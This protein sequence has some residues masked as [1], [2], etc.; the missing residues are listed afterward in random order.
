MSKIR[1]PNFLVP[2]P[3]PY[4]ASVLNKIGLPC[5][6]TDPYTSASYPSHGLAAWAIGN[7]FNSRF[8]IQKNYGKGMDRVP[9]CFYMGLLIH[10]SRYSGRYSQARAPQARARS[11]CCPQGQLVPLHPYFHWHHFNI[12]L[13]NKVIYL[14]ALHQRLELRSMLRRLWIDQETKYPLRLGNH[15]CVYV[16]AYLSRFSPIFS[17]TPFHSCRLRR[18]TTG[19]PLTENKVDNIVHADAVLDLSKHSRTGATDIAPCESIHPFIPA[20]MTG[21]SLP[22]LLCVAVHDV[23]VSTDNRGQVG[24]VDDQ[25]VTLGDTRT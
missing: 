24:L 4:V 7:I 11:R 17:C 19:A 12:N 25:K 16:C 14:R 23:Q 9:V 13:Q 21:I 15:V 2:L 10:G 20:K 22:H 1:R 6:A 3:K 5:G 8:W 18:S